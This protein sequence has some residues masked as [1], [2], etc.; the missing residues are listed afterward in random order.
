[1]DPTVEADAGGV[2][3]EEMF[4]W[5]LKTNQSWFE[6]HSLSECDSGV[7]TVCYN[8][9]VTMMEKYEDLESLHCFMIFHV[10][11]PACQFMLC[12]TA[13]PIYF[14]GVCFAK[15]F[16]GSVESRVIFL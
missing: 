15:V 4:S 16:V 1:M 5:P 3:V 12:L 13:F 6:C 9:N 10:T 7:M 8:Y 14:C 11:P 2:M